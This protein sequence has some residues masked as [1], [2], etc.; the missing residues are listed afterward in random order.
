MSC[1]GSYSN[2][3]DDDD[4]YYYTS[5]NAPQTEPPTTTEVV[6][7]CPGMACSC[8][9]PPSDLVRHLKDYHPDFFL[10]KKYFVLAGENTDRDIKV[11]E[12]AGRFFLL[13]VTVSDDEFVFRLFHMDGLGAV[14]AKIVL[15]ESDE[16]VISR[17]VVSCSIDAGAGGECQFDVQEILETFKIGNRRPWNIMCFC[18]IIVK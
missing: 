10:Q 17:K 7:I 2:F 1:C 9:M 5:N 18:E 4:D 6:A 15:F 16:R 14:E 13:Y 11:I 8:R 3:E 12:M